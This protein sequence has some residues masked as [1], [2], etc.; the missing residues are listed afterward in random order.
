MIENQ[1]DTDSRG[2]GSGEGRGGERREGR[3][4]R[5]DLAALRRWVASRYLR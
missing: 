2:H 1:P 5:K 4:E 3:G